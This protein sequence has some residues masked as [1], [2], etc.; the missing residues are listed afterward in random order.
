MAALNTRFLALLY[1]RGGLRL[2]GPG[3]LLL[4]VHY[5]TG[6]A[7]VPLGFAA[8]AFAERSPAAPRAAPRCGGMD[9]TRLAGGTQALMAAGTGA[10]AHARR[11]R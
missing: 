2:V 1:R 9:V 3:V 10:S 11:A 8:W 7:A 5:L 4:F 6:V